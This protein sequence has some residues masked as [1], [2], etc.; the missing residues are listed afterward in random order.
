[1]PVGDHRAG[2]LE[3]YDDA[4][5]VATL[6]ASLPNA[7]AESESLALVA[8]RLGKLL[9]LRSHSKHGASK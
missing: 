2:V 1:V 8:E 4:T 3:S 6:A 5:G 7:Y 9:I